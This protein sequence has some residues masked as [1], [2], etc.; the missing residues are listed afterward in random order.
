MS[1]KE[2]LLDVIEFATTDRLRSTLR[3]ICLK[4]DDAYALVC[5]ELLAPANTQKTADEKRQSGSSNGPVSKRKLD[6]Y[7]CPRFAVCEQCEREFDVLTDNGP[8]ACRWHEG[9]LEID[10]D[11]KTW[12]DWDEDVHG[13]MDDDAS[14]SEYPEGFVWECCGKRGGWKND[15][16]KSGPHKAEDYKKFKVSN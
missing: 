4:S 6:E 10:L 7:I 14:R 2:L 9:E 12:D 13:D 1:D 15:E 11:H 8:H 16:C 3:S 5:D